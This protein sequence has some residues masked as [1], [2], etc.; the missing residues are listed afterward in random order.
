[1]EDYNPKSWI[2]LIFTLHKSDTFSLLWKEIIFIAILSF[3][4]AYLQINYFP[5]A[6]HL[7]NLDKV[8]SLVGF[9]IS[10]LLV[11][12]TNTA[13]DRWY[14]GRK[15][16][17]ELVN[18]SR[19][20]ATK[21][22]SVVIKQEDRDYFER[23]VPNF[24]IATKDHLNHGVIIE[25]L[26]LTNEEIKILENASHKPLILVNALYHRIENIKKDQGLT[27]GELLILD[28]NLNA[29]MDSLGA[30]ERI[31]NTPIPISYSAFFKRFI[32]LFVCTIPLAFVYKFGYYSVIISTAIFYIL[33]SLEVLAEEIE[34][35]FGED[36]NDLPTKKLAEMIRKNVHEVFEIRK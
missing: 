17:G 6:H 12:R 8:Y 24:I 22:A 13:Y 25:N 11:F 31:K 36:A 29:F 28:K 33:V 26:D 35:P 27:D 14:E 19:N 16:W 7:N 21:L 18:D 1:M 32:F 20:L 2:K 4:I 5:N 15:K 23:M 30:C 10:L 3:S 9:V 34:D